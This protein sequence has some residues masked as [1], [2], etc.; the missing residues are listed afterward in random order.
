MCKHMEKWCNICYISHINDKFDDICSCGLQVYDQITKSVFRRVSTIDI[1]RSNYL[2]IWSPAHQFSHHF[3]G[4]NL[5]RKK[6]NI[7]EGT[8]ILASILD[9]H[10]PHGPPPRTQ[11]PIQQLISELQYRFSSTLLCHNLSANLAWHR[12]FQNLT[13]LIRIS[14]S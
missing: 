5:K 4:N 3:I 13:F 7:R 9:W 12:F 14:L 11:R 6:P 8:C 10:V 2:A 1:T